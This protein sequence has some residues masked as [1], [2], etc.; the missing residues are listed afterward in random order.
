MAGCEWITY[1]GQRILSIDHTGLRGDEIL[2]NMQA[3]NALI[4]KEPDDSVLSLADFTGTYA[5]DELVQY[6]QSDETKRAAQKVR[7]MAVVGITGLKKL[8]LNLYNSVTGS[9]AKPFDDIA[10]AKHYLIS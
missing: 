5:T 7:K 6:L 10:S 8:F 3:A 4:L 9:G 1:Q 2:R